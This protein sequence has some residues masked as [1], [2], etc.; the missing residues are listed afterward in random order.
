MKSEKENSKWYDSKGERFLDFYNKSQANEI[1]QIKKHLL[2]HIPKKAIILECGC[3]TGKIAKFLSEKEF[4]VTGIDISK[5]MIKIAKENAPNANFK[6]KSLYDLN[7]PAKTFDAIT[8]FFVLLHVEKDR[9]PSIFKSFN[10]ILKSN[11][12][13]LF[14]INKGKGEGYN[15]FQGKNVYFSSYSKKEIKEV[16]KKSGFKIIWQEDFL[17]KTPDKKTEHQMYF[18]VRKN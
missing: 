6:L 7:F 13:L 15:N 2:N 10:N 18:L 5:Q 12:F 4:L 8:S 17:F 11:G 16:L 9:L 3:G 14:S 1:I